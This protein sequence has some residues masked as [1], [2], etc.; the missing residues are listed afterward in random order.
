MELKENFRCV[1]KSSSW[2]LAEPAGGGRSIAQHHRPVLR[3]AHSRFPGTRMNK[4]QRAASMRTVTARTMSARLASS[5]R[6]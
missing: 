2:W 1:V 5:V 4:M 3:L 6:M